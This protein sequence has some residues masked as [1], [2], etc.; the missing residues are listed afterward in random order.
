[1]HTQLELAR[2]GSVTPAMQAVA[3]TERVSVE[4]V[5]A[6]IAAGRAVLPLN[7]AHT[8][9][10]PQIVGR[11]FRTKVNANIGRS[12]AIS[13]DEIE[14][15]K[16]Q[17]ALAAGA[18]YIM[19][20]SVGTCLASLRQAM[21]AQCPAPFGTV[22]IYEA[23]SRTGGAVEAFDPDVLLSVIAEQ[24]VQGV[25]FMTLHAG[26]LKAHVPLAMKRLAGIVSRGGAILAS[27]MAARGQENPLYTRWDEVLDICRAHDVTVSLGDG[28]RPGCQADASD[29]AQFAE[30][31]TLG[32]LVE[33]CRRRG[34]QVMVEGPGHVPFGQIQMNVER[35]IRVCAGAPFYVLGPVVTDVAPGYDH[36]TSCIGATAAAYYG[37]SLLCYVTPAEHLGLPT[38]TEVREGLVAYRIAAHAADVARNLPGARDWDDAMTRAR[39]RFDW[40]RQFDLALDGKHARERFGATSPVMEEANDHCTMCGADFCAMRI[41]RKLADKMKG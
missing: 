5:V 17:T 10:V 12:A 29:A 30:L 33:R 14:L 24:A 4:Q 13:C 34:V 21:L 39:T 18:D 38:E 26:L 40:N 2:V 36:I 9:L 3:Q 41:S 22:P 23:V 32:Q 6:E 37:A 28:L 27:W 35:E 15:A 1:M 25:D 20:L 19:D 8:R 7:P 11:K 16:L 31:D